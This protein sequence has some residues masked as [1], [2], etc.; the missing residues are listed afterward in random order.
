MSGSGTFS[1]SFV[2]R[3]APMKGGRGMILCQCG[4]GTLGNKIALPHYCPVCGFDLWAF[5]NRY[6]EE[7]GK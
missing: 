5:F 4:W 1:G 6:G 3:V 7:E 2:R